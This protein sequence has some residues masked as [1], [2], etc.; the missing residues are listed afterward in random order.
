M[1]ALATVQIKTFDDHTLDY[2]RKTYP[3]R[4][5]ELGERNVRDLIAH[6]CKRVAKYGFKGDADITKYIEVMLLFGDD[7]DADPR[8]T[9]AKTILQQRKS[10]AVKIKA[11]Y[12]EAKERCKSPGLI[13][14]THSPEA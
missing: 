11:L 3:R 8:L 2:I 13:D 14:F 4:F 9:W 5:D 1:A 10:P 12:E 7:F 6:G